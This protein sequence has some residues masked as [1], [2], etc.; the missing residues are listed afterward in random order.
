MLRTAILV[1]LAYKNNAPPARRR[2]ISSLLDF[3]WIGSGGLLL[4]LSALRTAELFTR[5]LLVEGLAT[6]DADLAAFIFS[7]HVLDCGEPSLYLAKLR[8]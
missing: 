3:L 2:S 7:A 5:Q 8:A 6:I 4:C 1:T